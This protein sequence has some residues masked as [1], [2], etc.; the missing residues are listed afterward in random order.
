MKKRKRMARATETTR[1]QWPSLYGRTEGYRIQGV[2]S[3]PG[4]KK[5]EVARS[6][7]CKA[8][9]RPKG[10]VSDSNVVEWALDIALRAVGLLNP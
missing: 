3:E 1:K 6:Y 9:E 5:F 4:G 10:A 2:L 8:H 7:V